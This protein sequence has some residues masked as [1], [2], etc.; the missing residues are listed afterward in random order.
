MTDSVKPI[1]RRRYLSPQRHQQ[2][3][4]TRQQIEDAAARLFSRA[5]YFGTTIEA[6]ANDAGVAVPTVYAVFGNKRAIL[7]ALMDKA[8]FGSDPPGTP[9]SERSWYRDLASEPDPARL[10]AGWGEYLCQVNAR[11][12]PVQQ[13]VESAAPS[14]PAIAALWQRAKEQRLAGQSAVAQLLADRKALRPALTADRAADILYVLSD[15]RLYS[16]YVLDRGWSPA[17]VGEWI[18]ESLCALLLPAGAG[19]D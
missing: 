10:L 7:S 2:A 3:Q 9:T 1:A 19:P 16:A 15:P 5:G 4:A 11:V 12:A 13:I 17:E 18:G 6:V 8:I 14:D